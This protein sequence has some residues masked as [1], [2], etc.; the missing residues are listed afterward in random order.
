MPQFA[1]N[2]VQIDIFL[3]Q[4]AQAVAENWACHVFTPMIAMTQMCFCTFPI[5][6]LGFSKCVCE[7][8]T[9]TMGQVLLAFLKNSFGMILC[10]FHVR[11]FF[12]FKHWFVFTLLILSC[13]SLW[14][15]EHL[16]FSAKLW[17]FISILM[18]VTYC[19][20][21]SQWLRFSTKSMTISGPAQESSQLS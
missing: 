3:D 21:T 1:P 12:F 2:S 11:S 20:Y 6:V 15:C 5:R 10:L 16:P 8:F 7:C 18:S 14:C 4:G 19:K 17:S 9:N 13:P